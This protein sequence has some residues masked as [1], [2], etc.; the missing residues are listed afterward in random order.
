MCWR[1]GS[2]LFCGEGIC[3]GPVI[4]EW[5]WDL[6]VSC[7]FLFTKNCAYTDQ[8][9][10]QRSLSTGFRTG[11]KSRVTS[12]CG[13][14]PHGKLCSSGVCAQRLPLRAPEVVLIKEV[15]CAFELFI[16]SKWTAA[17]GW[18]LACF[19]FHPYNEHCYHSTRVTSVLAWPEQ[20][21]CA[22]SRQRESFSSS[23]RSRCW[24]CTWLLKKTGK[25]SI[26]FI[27]AA[28]GPHKNKFVFWINLCINIKCLDL[29]ELLTCLFWK[30][31]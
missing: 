31:E 19:G 15:Q 16:C 23:Q 18:H 21:V 2:G 24:A 22:S 11:C 12:S 4:R 26:S 20:S 29:M 14:L 10:A 8:L 25:L 27:R 13:A 7:W 3:D 30:M 28:E 17:G 5:R 6:W 9:H 1:Q